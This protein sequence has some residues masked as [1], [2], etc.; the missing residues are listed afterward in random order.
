MA[1]DSSSGVSSPRGYADGQDADFPEERTPET[2]KGHQEDFVCQELIGCE[3]QAELSEEEEDAGLVAEAEAVAA[4]WMLD[5]LCLS[6]CRAFRDGR[7]QDFHRT[8]DSAEGERRAAGGGGG[9]RFPALEPIQ[10]LESLVNLAFFLFGKSE[11][12]AD[13][14]VLRKCAQPL[15]SPQAVLQVLL[16]AICLRGGPCGRP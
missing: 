9:G 7:S 13:V 16:V 1:E 14:G 3:V 11:T 10:R 4:G 6:L 8:R 2:A 15:L 5:F 12:R